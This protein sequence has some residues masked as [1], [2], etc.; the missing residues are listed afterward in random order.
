VFGLSFFEMVVIALVGIVVLGPKR[1]PEMMRTAGQW[2]TKLR[3]LSGDL[4]A[5][6]GIDDLIRQEGLEKEIQELR[7][8]SRIN[9]ID[10]LMSP[11][12]TA[13]IAAAASPARAT[14]TTPKLEQPKPVVKSQPLRAREYPVHGCDAYGALAD[15]IAPK[16]APLPVVPSNVA[17]EPAPLVAP[18]E[19]VVA[20]AVDPVASAPPAA[21]T[22]EGV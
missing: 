6:S 16:P 21:A 8:L 9:V 1:L 13:G 11:A 12:A 22:K 20:A 10:T 18:V 14:V 2:V 3:R 5:Q 4:R 17:P 7:S 15:D 19:P